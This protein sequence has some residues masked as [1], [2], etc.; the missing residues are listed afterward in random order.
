MKKEK[1]K[2]KSHVLSLTICCGLSKSIQFCGCPISRPNPGLGSQGSRELFL[3]MFWD[4]SLFY[5]GL[6][7]DSLHIFC[8]LITWGPCF[9]MSFQGPTPGFVQQGCRVEGGGWRMDGWALR[10]Y[11]YSQPPGHLRLS[12]V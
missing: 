6:I 10:S 3:S 4:W 12:E 1:R 8:F 7:R 2:K 11:T 9:K 5:K